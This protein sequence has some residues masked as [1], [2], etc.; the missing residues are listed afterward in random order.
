MTRF[1]HPP[2]TPSRLRSKVQVLTRLDRRLFRLPP[3][4]PAALNPLAAR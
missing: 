3:A 2:L 4:I 1:A